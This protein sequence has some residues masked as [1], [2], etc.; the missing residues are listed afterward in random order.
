[1]EAISS[2]PLEKIRVKINNSQETPTISFNYA[3]SRAEWELQDMMRYL[4]KYAIVTVKES[5]WPV[6]IQMPLN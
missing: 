6:K 5:D 2:L 4:V 1:M 3:P